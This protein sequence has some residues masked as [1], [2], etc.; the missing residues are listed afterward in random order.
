MRFRE[1][2]DPADPLLADVVRLH[3]DAFSGS[4]RASTDGL[5]D[6][7]RLHRSKDRIWHLLV[8]EDEGALFGFARVTYSF[9]GFGHLSH[10]AV[11]PH[12]RQQGLGGAL[13]QG[14]LEACEIDARI[15]KRPF[16]GLIFEI[17]EDK[18]DLAKFFSERGT[19]LI[20]STYLRPSLPEPLP[21]TLQWLEVEPG[22]SRRAQVITF[23]KEIHGLSGMHRL[24]IQTLA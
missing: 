24:V 1:I 11:V 14:V 5:I 3:A 8:I 9:A 7:I 18:P 16:F 21:M 15:Y 12:A 23:F 4:F 2:T 19:E 22:L 17:A 20:S 13:I 10:L 6:E